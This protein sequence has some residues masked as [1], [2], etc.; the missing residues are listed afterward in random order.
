MKK[1]LVAL[2]GVL[3]TF[4]LA[5]CGNS[6]VATTSGGKVT[7]SAYYDS[8]K[9]TSSGTSIL[10]QMILN[11]VLEKQYGDSVSTKAVTK[12]YNTYKAQ[13]GSS[14]SS[15]LSQNSMTKASFKEELRSN[16][17]LKAAV[18]HYSDLSTTA[19]NKQWKEYQPNVTVQRIQVADKATAENI[20]KQL[21][22][23]KNAKDLTAKFTALAKSKS[24]DTTSASTGGTLAAFNNTDTTLTSEFKKAA[25][26]L[27]QGKYTTTPVKTTSGYDVIL[28]VKNA[29][30]GKKA[31]HVSDL[32]E[33]IVTENMANSTKLQ[34]IVGK[35]LKKGNVSI[36]DKD[37]KDVLSSYLSSSSSK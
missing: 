19:V 28:S 15:V 10:Q 29:G 5:G 32:K 2:A 13:Y 23:Q 8:L 6:T 16:L 14:F 35:V 12:Q 26:D 7:E 9:K 21:D 30:K 17:L 22:K 18:K 24:T 3:L 25:F 11:K 4:T 20:I 34:K 36:K 31:D 33:Q 27:K 1:W 37:L